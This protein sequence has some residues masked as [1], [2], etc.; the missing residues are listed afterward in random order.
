[1]ENQKKCYKERWK[2]ETKPNKSNFIYLQY[3]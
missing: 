1:M 3:T 2:M